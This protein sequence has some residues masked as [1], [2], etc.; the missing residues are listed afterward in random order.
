MNFRWSEPTHRND[1]RSMAGTNSQTVRTEPLLDNPLPNA[2]TLMEAIGDLPAIEAGQSADYFSAPPQ[3]DF[4]RWARGNATNVTMHDATKHSEHML[5][6]IR[7]AG[8]NISSIPSHLVSSGFSSSYSRLDAE[9]PSTTLTVNFVHPASNRCIHPLQHRALTPRE[10]ARIQSFP[11]SFVFCGTRAQIVKQIG[12]AVPPLLAKSVGEAIVAAE[13]K[14]MVVGEDARA[15]HLS[16]HI[17]S[18]A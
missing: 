14:G 10:G 12:N 13:L 17:E 2:V 1:F 5:E 8:P 3:N 11:D 15:A 4:Q 6:I 16:D 9:K 18:P 7:Y